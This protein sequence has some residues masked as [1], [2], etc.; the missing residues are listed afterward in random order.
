MVDLVLPEDEVHIYKESIDF[1]EKLDND[2]LYSLS[3]SENQ[4]LN[5]YINPSDKKRFALGR[6]ITRSMLKRYTGKCFN[7]KEFLYN[8]YKKPIIRESNINIEF[9][10][11]HSENIVLVAFSKAP[12]GIDIEIEKNF[13]W[14]LVSDLVFTSKELNYLYTLTDEEFKRIFFKLWTNKEAYIK[15][16]G[17]G[18]FLPAN[19]IEVKFGKEF[20]EIIDLNGNVQKV[21]ICTN[22]L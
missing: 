15:A 16:S 2:V 13:D 18:F 7:C 20:N 17:K 4:R 6:Y 19:T 21:F 11:T 10:I 14:S 8:A 9:N 22:E 5:S 1:L 12:V 3:K